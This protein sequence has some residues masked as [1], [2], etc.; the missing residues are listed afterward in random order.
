MMARYIRQNGRNPV[1]VLLKPSVSLD[2][3][4]DIA[5]R[6]DAGEILLSPEASVLLLYMLE[7]RALRLLG[8]G[9][10]VR[11]LGVTLKRGLDGTVCV[12]FKSHRLD[13]T[14]KQFIDSKQADR[15]CA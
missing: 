3:L 10:E 6:F 13:S 15:N 12:L 14:D 8:P 2:E 9:D 1:D 5:S 11:Q 4:L 7:E